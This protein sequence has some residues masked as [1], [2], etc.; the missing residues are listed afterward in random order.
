MPR[1]QAGR[2]DQRKP[3]HRGPKR[4]TGAHLSRRTHVRTPDT[5][6]SPELA[7]RAQQLR[8]LRV[9]TPREY[10]TKAVVRQ[11]EEA[12]VNGDAELRADGLRRIQ[13][14]GTILG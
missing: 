2:A 7:F 5:A 12:R 6:G 14:F 9:R 3:D 8:R 4:A 11:V 10:A 13:R 1:C